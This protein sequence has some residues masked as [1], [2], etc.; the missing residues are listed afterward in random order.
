MDWKDIGSKVIS[1]APLIGGALGGPVGAIATAAGGLLAS[2]LGVEASPTAVNGALT[3]DNIVRLKEMELKHEEAFLSWQNQQVQA[4]LENVKSARNREVMMAK[5]GMGFAS[6]GPPA[7]ISLVIVGGFFVILWLYMAAKMEGQQPND[8]LMIL[9]GALASA[10]L[11]VVNYYLG[12]SLG[13]SMK[14]SPPGPRD[15][16]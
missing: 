14:N 16:K 13:S 10:F 6:W 9:M 2:F 7:L 15:L 12:S 1:V 8:G 4:D 11:T 5:A 3:S